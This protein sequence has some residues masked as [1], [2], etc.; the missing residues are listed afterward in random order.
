VGP[1]DRLGRVEESPGFVPWFNAHVS[2]GIT[3][4]SFTAVN[5]TGLLI[6]ITLAFWTVQSSASVLLVVAW[7]SFLMLTNAIFHI[8]GAVIDQAY[9][10]GLVTAIVLYLPYCTWVAAQVVRGRRAATSLV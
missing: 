8:T 4:N 10:P 9:V 7:L 2:P 5:A 3:Q 1:P 6:T